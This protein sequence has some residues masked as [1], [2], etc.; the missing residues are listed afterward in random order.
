MTKKYDTIVYIGRFQPFHN[1]HLRVLEEISKLTDDVIIMIGSSG[2]PQTVRNPFL[3]VD[4][5]EAIKLSVGNLFVSGWIAGLPDFYSDETWS[6]EI[7]KYINNHI[8]EKEYPNEYTPKVGIVGNPLDESYTYQKLFPEL[9]FI[10]IY[11]DVEVHATE[12]REFMFGEGTIPAMDVPTSTSDLMHGFM[13][14]EKYEDLRNE[15]FAISNFKDEYS[16]LE[17]PPIFQAADCC[18]FHEEKVLLVRRGGPIGKNL[19]AMPGGFVEADEPIWKAA[20]RELR[21]ETS[22]DLSDQYFKYK[23]SYQV[24]SV[25]RSQLGRMITNVFNINLTNSIPP[26]VTAGDDASGAFWFP[27]KDL[28]RDMMFDDHFYIIND[29]WEMKKKEE[30]AYTGEVQ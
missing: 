6:Q 19:Y 27:V 18:I 11:E 13:Q 23:T 17:F 21:E 9:E 28:K 22:L 1:G 20:Q 29:L 16:G 30:D 5:A 25:N 26:L 15:Y 24:D 7:I 4:R 14:T 12:V 8:N 3:A 10:P 2:E